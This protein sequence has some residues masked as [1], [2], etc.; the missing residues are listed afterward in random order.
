MSKNNNISSLIKN[1][2]RNVTISK[3]K[4]NVILMPPR[5]TD[6][7]IMALFGGVLKLVKRKIELDADYEIFNLNNSIKKLQQQLKSKQAECVRLKN[8]IINLKSKQFD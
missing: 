7:D 5:I 3:P 8:E 1:K 4:C 6:E 2:K